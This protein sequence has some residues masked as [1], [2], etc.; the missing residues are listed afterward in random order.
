[1]SRRTVDAHAIVDPVYGNVVGLGLDI[2]AAWRDAMER[3]GSTD[4]RDL[5]RSGYVSV[6]V[7]LSVSIDPMQLSARRRDRV[8]G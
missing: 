3:P 6:P 2:S 1:V 5:Q 8:A 4:W 7:R